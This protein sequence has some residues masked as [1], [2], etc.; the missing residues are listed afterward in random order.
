MRGGTSVKIYRSFKA[1]IDS[2]AEQKEKNALY[3]ETA[4]LSAACISAKNGRK[5]VFEKKCLNMETTILKKSN[6]K[7]N[8]KP[9]FTD[10]KASVFTQRR[11][12]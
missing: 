2:A 12:V 6:L 9:L 11:T 10:S 4:G 8:K 5:R 3:L 7:N 1:G